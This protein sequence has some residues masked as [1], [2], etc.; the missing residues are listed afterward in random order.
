M[1][2]NNAEDKNKQT[3]PTEFLKTEKALGYNRSPRRAER[4]VETSCTVHVLSVDSLPLLPYSI[5]VVARNLGV[6]GAPKPRESHIPA[7]GFLNIL[8]IV[9]REIQVHLVLITARGTST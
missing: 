9:F 6:F 5:D 4:P 7:H 1:R 2:H 3:E 8:L